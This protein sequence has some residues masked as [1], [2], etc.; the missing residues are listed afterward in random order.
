MKNRIVT[1]ILTLGL[2]VGCQGVLNIEPAQS[3]STEEALSDYKSLLTAL[4]GAY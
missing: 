3:L 4:Y 2:S 1:L